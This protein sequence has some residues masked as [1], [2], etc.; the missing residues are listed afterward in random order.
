MSFQL[1][2]WGEYHNTYQGRRL[3]KGGEGG[4]KTLFIIVECIHY[5]FKPDQP[6]IHRHK[7][8]INLVNLNLDESTTDLKGT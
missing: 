3:T 7:S 5:Y 4:M 2:S 6:L 1:T 8:Q